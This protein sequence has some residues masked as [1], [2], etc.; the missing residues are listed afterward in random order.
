MIIYA[1]GRVGAELHLTPDLLSSSVILAVRYHSRGGA[2]SIIAASEGL[3]GN[4]AINWVTS[5]TRLGVDE[6]H[7]HRLAPTNTARQAILI[8]L[9]QPDLEAAP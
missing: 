9:I 5:L 8:D 2:A 1:P 3:V 4:A 7:I 6:F